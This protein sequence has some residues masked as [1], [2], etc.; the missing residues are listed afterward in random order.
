MVLSAVY[1]LILTSLYGVIYWTP[2]VIKAFGASG[3][4]NG[5]L[6]ALP[7]LVTVPMLRI[8]PKR[9]RREHRS[10]IIAMVVLAILGVVA[11]LLS[12]VVPENWMRLW[13]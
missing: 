2:T 11:F 13:R 10:V 9:L 3:T 7:W 5:L 8:L 4:Q 1:A 6:M 12:T